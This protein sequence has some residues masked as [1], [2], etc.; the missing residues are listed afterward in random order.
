M[1][2]RAESKPEVPDVT[3]NFVAQNQGAFRALPLYAGGLGIVSILVNRVVAGVRHCSLIPLS[4]GSMQH[5]DRH[6]M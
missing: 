2:L 3:F 6:I 1:V 4:F 5:L